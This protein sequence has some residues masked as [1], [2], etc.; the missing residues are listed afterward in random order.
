MRIV[1]C[2]ETG[3][4]K[5]YAQLLHDKTGLPVL[6]LEE[7]EQTLEQG[8]TAVFLG[9]LCAG[10]L[11]GL[12]RAKKR[13]HLKAVCAVGMADAYD[14]AALAS[15]SGL[16]NTPVFYLRGGYA[17]DK[18]RGIHK[19]MMAVAE[20]AIAGKA[21]KAP[22]GQEMIDAMEHGADWVDPVQ[23]EAVANLLNNT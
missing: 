13:F 1:Y 10:S 12:K 22:N 8:S 5:R 9:W 20:K 7:A 15:R 21:K 4:T 6:S 23:L 11:Q 17:P 3:F 19:A 2:S 16:G 18:L 14:A